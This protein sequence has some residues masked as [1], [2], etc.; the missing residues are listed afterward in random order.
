MA[1]KTTQSKNPKDLVARQKVNIALLPS[2]GIIHGAMACMDGAE[3][4]DPYNWREEKI[5]FVG[6]ISAI[7]RHGLDLL[8]GEDCA[9]DSLCH[10]LGHII[11]TAS[12]LIDAIENDCVIDDRPKKGRAAAILARASGTLAAKAKMKAK[13]A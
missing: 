12:I 8:D 11:A 3:K 1:K 9:S 5:S 4:Y 10:H 6:Y 13:A 7:Q 2:S